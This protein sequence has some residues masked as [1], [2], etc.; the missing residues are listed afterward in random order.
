MI[1]ILFCSGE[2]YPFSKSGGLA[3][4]AAALPKALKKIGHEVTIITPFYQSIK[5]H[6]S[7]MEYLGERTITMGIYQKKAMYYKIIYDDEKKCFHL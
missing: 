2:A 7:E 3:D 1:K 4:V 5:P 6:L